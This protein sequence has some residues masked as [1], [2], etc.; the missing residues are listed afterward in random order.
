MKV[1]GRGAGCRE[2]KIMSSCVLPVFFV[3]VNFKGR[4]RVS[5]C[6]RRLILPISFW[7]LR[8]H[9]INDKNKRPVC[10]LYGHV[11]PKRSC[12]HA[13][14]QG[15]SCYVLEMFTENLE[16]ETVMPFLEPLMTRLVQMLQ[17]PKRGV[18]VRHYLC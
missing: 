17:T 18:K 15:V 11:K 1:N 4:D 12:T 5:T 13:R 14:K 16:P 7:H 9:H 2:R 6:E 10:F 8:P 3:S